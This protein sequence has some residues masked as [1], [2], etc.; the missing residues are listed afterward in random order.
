MEILINLTLYIEIR[1]MSS[2]ELGYSQVQK[3]SCPSLSAKISGSVEYENVSF[4]D[5]CHG[6]MRF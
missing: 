1:L 5:K 2:R 4:R 6:W 3:V